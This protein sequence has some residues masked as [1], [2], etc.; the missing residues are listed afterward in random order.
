MGRSLGLMC[1]AS[2]HAVRLDS[3]VTGAVTFTRAT[4]S[5]AHRV[6]LLV[7]SPLLTPSTENN[8]NTQLKHTQEKAGS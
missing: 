6:K 1:K 3:Q 5:A 8:N 7:N 2:L 4:F